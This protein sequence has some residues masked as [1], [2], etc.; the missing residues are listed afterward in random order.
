MV[1]ETMQRAMIAAVVL[2]VLNAG[3][4]ASS[5]AADQM[6]A[7]QQA[8][9]FQQQVLVLHVYLEPLHR[10]QCGTVL[11]SFDETMLWQL[12]HS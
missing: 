10:C 9:Q 2:T 1:A 8:L 11:S 6:L 5:V 3:W 7:Q 12:Q 4:R